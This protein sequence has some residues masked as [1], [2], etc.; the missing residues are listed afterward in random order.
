M[1]TEV[2]RTN[3]YSQFSDV[4]FSSVALAITALVDVSKFLVGPHT[5]K[6]VE[7]ILLG[8]EHLRAETEVAEDLLD[9]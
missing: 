6:V 8:A 4:R 1:G 5:D 2:P 3:I 9:V 7:R